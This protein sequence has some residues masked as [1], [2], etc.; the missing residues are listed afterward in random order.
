V[1]PDSPRPIDA[2]ALEKPVRIREWVSQMTTED[3]QGLIKNNLLETQALYGTEVEIIE[4]RGDWV[5]VTIGDQPSKKHPNGYP[6]WV[7]KVQLSVPKLKEENAVDKIAIVTSKTTTLEHASKGETLEI[8]FLTRLPVLYEEEDRYKVATPDGVQY[9]NKKDVMIIDNTKETKDAP[10]STLGERIVEQGK[11]FLGLEY[12]WAGMSAFGYDCSG[13]SYSMHRAFGINTPRDASD[14]ASTGKLVEKEDLLPGDMVFF[15]TPGKETHV[16]MYVGDNQ[17]IHSPGTPRSIEIIQLFGGPRGEDYCGARRHWS[18][19][20]VK[21][22]V[23]EFL[24]I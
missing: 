8:S 3:K 13:F 21:V 6:G 15:G 14:Q 16:G 12:L 7:P 19:D 9:V 24:G 5:K 2:P 11:V 18:E 10:K 1:S 20:S 17:M 22:P 23:K 4:E